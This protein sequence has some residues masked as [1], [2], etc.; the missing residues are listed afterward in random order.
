[1][2][3]H[4]QRVI[5]EKKELDEKINNLLKFID[6]NPMFKRLPEEEQHRLR[7]QSDL[8]IRYSGV[9]LDRINNFPKD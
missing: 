5:D 7:L 3:D 8:M 6:E 4:E 2:E 1:M 9:L